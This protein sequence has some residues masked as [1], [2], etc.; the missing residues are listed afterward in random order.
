M[1][2]LKV[3]KD[4]IKAV[5]EKRIAEAEASSKAVY[6]KLLKALKPLKAKKIKAKHQKLKQ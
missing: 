4:K 3:S 6:A 2:S 5:G 1:K